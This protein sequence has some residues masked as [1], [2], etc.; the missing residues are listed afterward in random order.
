MPIFRSG[1]PVPGWCGL[2][3]FDIVDL[4]PGHAHRYDRL[5]PRDKLIV[6]RGACRVRVGSE[7]HDASVGAQFDLSAPGDAFEVTGAGDKAQATVDFGSGGTKRLVLRY[8]P[9]V[10]L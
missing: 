3:G 10:K 6:V 8:A 9:L 2:H 5:A 4:A 7:E 1:E